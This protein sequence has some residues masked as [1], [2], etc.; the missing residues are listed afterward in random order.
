MKARIKSLLA[1]SLIGAAALPAAAQDFG[2]TCISN[3]SGSCSS[4]ESQLNL[5]VSGSGNS[6]TFTF[7]NLAGGL[8]SSI[9]DIYFNQAFSFLSALSPVITDSGAGVA[10][11]SGA[12]PGDPPGTGNTWT[13]SYS[14]DSDAPTQP[15]GANPG[16]FVAFTFT[17]TD[18]FSQS[19]AAFG[20]GGL[21]AVHLQGLPGGYSETL[22]TGGSVTPVPE[23]QTYALMLA[24]LAVVGFM[25]RR[26]SK[27]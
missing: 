13:T 14:A 27:G 2:F 22:V 21:A 25:G 8:A 18:I 1:A 7:A 19:L 12:N 11:S 4:F 15:N 26:R 10:F 17:G 24:G 3:N 23:P 16:E 5:N 9:A 6:V 20:S